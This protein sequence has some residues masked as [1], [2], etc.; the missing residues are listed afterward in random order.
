MTTP[1]YPKPKRPGLALRERQ[2]AEAEKESKIADYL[3]RDQDAA[4]E[5]KRSTKRALERMR[6][7]LK[8]TGRGE[9]LGDE[10]RVHIAP[11]RRGVP[12]DKVA[13]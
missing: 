4:K 1:Y 5:K 8:K 7:A 13:D 11:R 3:H 10:E 2:A 9:Y 6:A 12:P